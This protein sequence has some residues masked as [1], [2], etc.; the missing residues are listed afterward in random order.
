MSLS[1]Y[2]LVYED[3]LIVHMAT[4]MKMTFAT[5][6]IKT[7]SSSPLHELVYEDL[8]VVLTA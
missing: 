4:A 6:P 2:E 8:L 5:S 7:F 1:A 3:L